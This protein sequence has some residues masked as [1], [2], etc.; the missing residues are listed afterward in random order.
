MKFYVYVLARPDGSPF[1]VGKGSRRRWRE[2][3]NEASRGHKCP[4]C[5][6]IRKIWKSGGQV[7]CYVVLETDDE[8]EAFQHER[9]LIALYGRAKLTNLTDGGEGHSGCEKPVGARIRQLAAM[10]VLYA[11]P[12]QRERIGRLVSAAFSSP[13]KRAQ[14]SAR[15]KAVWSD[16][17]MRAKRIAI[18][19]AL[20]TDEN[21]QANLRAAN[22]AAANSPEGRAQRRAQMKAWLASPEGKAQRS[23]MMKARYA[24]PEERRKQSERMKAVAARRKAEREQGS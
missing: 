12:A 21:Y 22:K 3:E 19:Q 4:K 13:E 17:S 11:D 23:A 10:K 5:S 18:L 7:Q 20:Q 15:M 14:L 9:D 2:H 16:P 24:D 1:Y 6:V 8:A